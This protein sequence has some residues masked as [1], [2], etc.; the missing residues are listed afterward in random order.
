MFAK[1]VKLALACCVFAGAMLF[2][3]AMA[4][5]AIPAPVKLD[6]KSISAYLV[7]QDFRGAI[8]NIER[9]AK[10]SLPP[11]EYQ[12]GTIAREIGTN[13]GDPTLANFD[14]KPWVAMLLQAPEGYGPDKG[15]PPIALFIPVKDPAPVEKGLQA[16]QMKTAFADGIVIAALTDDFLATARAAKADYAKFAASK[17]PCDA[18]V[19]VSLASLVDTFGPIIKAQLGQGRAQGVK[20]MAQM[21]DNPQFAAM[22]LTPELA[23]QLIHL[24]FNTVEGLVAQAD[25][26]QLDVTLKPDSVLLEETLAAKSGTLFADTMSGTPP[27]PSANLQS[28]LTKGFYMMYLNLD[29]KAYSASLRKIIAAVANDPNTA[30]L[31]RNPFVTKL[32]QS[33]DSVGG[34]TV[35]STSAG[36]N[37]PEIT[38]VATVTDEAKYLT[39]QESMIG[40]F[41]KDSL[42]SKIYSSMGM[43]FEMNFERGVRKHAGIDVNKMDM[44]LDMP[45]LPKEQAA[46]MQKLIPKPE[47]AIVKG[48]S[49][50]GSNPAKLDAM[51]DK[52]LKGD[53][54]PSGVTLKSMTAFGKDKNLYFDYDA[55]GYMKYSMTL[56]DPNGA[57]AAALK[58]IKD[59]E[60]ILIGYA[61][62]SGRGKLQLQ[63]PLLPFIEGIK[64]FGKLQ[65]GIV[66]KQPETNDGKF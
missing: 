37:G 60:P 64:A 42:L 43:T 39:A 47:I 11:N 54:S 2:R 18:R 10:Q 23:T 45:M 57:G 6:N 17:L 51:I 24:F 36:E 34:E 66:P 7:I 9:I 25:A 31:A 32:V 41:G 56:M 1:S 59:S 20:T 29:M 44:K 61:Q 12:P 53:F 27:Q 30:D 15:P 35:Y 22:G 48:Y 46:N 21:K 50:T 55:M 26:V 40:M 3:G 13:F 33:I 62:G 38:A 4:E 16:A 14:S 19:Y 52:T 65:Q 5:D 49:I 58:Q 63:V 8:D 28:F